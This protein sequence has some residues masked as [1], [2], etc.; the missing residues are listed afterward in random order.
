MVLDAGHL[1]EFDSSVL[2][3]KKEGGL[4]WGMVD[5]SMDRNKLRT[6]MGL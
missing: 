4:F 3:L 1:M 5:D 2:P 6:M